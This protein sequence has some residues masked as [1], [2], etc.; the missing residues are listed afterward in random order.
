MEIRRLSGKRRP[1]HR[2]FHPTVVDSR[3]NTT[4][5]RAPQK[6][7]AEPISISPG[8]AVLRHK[9][10]VIST[11]NEQAKI[12]EKNSLTADRTLSTQKPTAQ[13]GTVSNESTSTANLPGASHR[14]TCSANTSLALRDV[15][16]DIGVELQEVVD[17]I[18]KAGRIIVFVG[19]GIST[20]CGIPVST[21]LHSMSSLDNNIPGLSVRNGSP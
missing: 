21:N 2:N 16:N 3:P 8:T 12:N 4:I 10:V 6:H 13:W 11:L 19:A 20:K 15:P 17:H 14:T 9:R 5:N 18:Y 1:S 7:R